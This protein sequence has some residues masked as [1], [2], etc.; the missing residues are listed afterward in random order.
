ME[1]ITEKLSNH[2][3]RLESLEDYQKEQNGTMNRINEKLDELI[4]AIGGGM[5]AILLLLVKIL[6]DLAG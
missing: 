4:W 1:K 2:E 3:S 5:F 6:V